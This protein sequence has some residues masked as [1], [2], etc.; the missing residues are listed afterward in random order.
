M[1]IGSRIWTFAVTFAILPGPC[2][3]GP[4]S[5]GSP[6]IDATAARTRASL[7]AISKNALPNSS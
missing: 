3:M 2:A 4:T 1:T 6:A 5:N 7:T